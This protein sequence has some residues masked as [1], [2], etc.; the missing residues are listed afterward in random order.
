MML[1]QARRAG[2][3]VFSG[4]RADGTRAISVLRSAGTCKAALKILSTG[5]GSPARPST[6]S[7]GALLQKVK[8]LGF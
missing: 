3:N 7:P 4:Q 8:V 1:V 2:P 5:A 6:A